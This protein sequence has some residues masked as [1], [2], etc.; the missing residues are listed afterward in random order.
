MELPFFKPE[1]NHEEFSEE[2]MEKSEEYAKASNDGDDVF[3]CEYEYD[4]HWH[5]FKRLADIDDE[6]EDSNES[7]DDKYWNIS[8]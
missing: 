7:D 6:R 2:V 8:K 3:L 1:Q 4:I 5:S